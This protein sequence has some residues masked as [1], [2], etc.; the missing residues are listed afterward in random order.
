MYWED[1]EY[2]DTPR[3]YMS[4]RKEGKIANDPTKHYPNKD[5]AALLRKIKSDTGLSEEEIRS[6]KKY[7]VM[8]SEAQKRGREP[9]F[10]ARQRRFYTWK[11]KQACRET[12]LAK[13]HP[14][15][16]AALQRILNNSMGWGVALLFTPML[17]AKEVVARYSNKN[18][19]HATN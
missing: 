6:H 2:Y 4:A 3:K 19:D 10:G 11:L 12:G 14:D 18:K 13:E 1:D 17:T 15:T 7:R 8:L 9:K 16:I 5:E